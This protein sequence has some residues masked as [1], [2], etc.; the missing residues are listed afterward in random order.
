[1]IK[2][3]SKTKDYDVRYMHSLY[4]TL[5]AGIQIISIVQGRQI[6]SEITKFSYHLDF[7][8]TLVKNVVFKQAQLK[9][10]TEYLQ[11]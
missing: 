8:L 4:K 11:M 6:L 5:P 3:L 1:M 7:D 9:I 2:Q 10:R